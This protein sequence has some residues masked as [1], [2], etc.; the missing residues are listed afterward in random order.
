MARSDGNSTFCHSFSR[1]FVFGREIGS[2]FL[3]SRCRES[4]TTT[5]EVGFKFP[6]LQRW[7]PHKVISQIPLIPL[8]L[9]NPKSYIT[10][11]T[12]YITL[13]ITLYNPYNPI[14]RDLYKALAPPTSVA[15]PLA[16][17]VHGV[18]RKVFAREVGLH[19]IPSS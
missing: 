8:L 13:A 9:G 17:L 5:A 10:P 3:R 4:P 16:G 1:A 18:K 19:E 2:G 14:L 6:S 11:T 12:P 15:H 7:D